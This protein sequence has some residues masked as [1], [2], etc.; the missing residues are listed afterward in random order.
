MK[1]LQYIQFKPL[2]DN[3]ITD[4]HTLLT[5]TS[6]ASGVFASATPTHV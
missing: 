5:E 3:H 4:H 1:G 6:E 2:V